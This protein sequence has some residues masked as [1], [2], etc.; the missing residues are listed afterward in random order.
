METEDALEKL[1]QY[2]ERS[3]KSM[4]D[5]EDKIREPNPI[6]EAFRSLAI[7]LTWFNAFVFAGLASFS[8]LGGV[9]SY[10]VMA[11]ATA[12]VSAI[13]TLQTLK[14]NVRL[15]VTNGRRTTLDDGFIIILAPLLLLSIYLVDY[16]NT[17]AFKIVHI[18]FSIMWVLQI[19]FLFFTKPDV[20]YMKDHLVAD[21]DEV[22]IFD[23][24]RKIVVIVGAL[25]GILLSIP[26][27]T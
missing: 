11:I 21:Y 14:A 22:E 13:V 23:T 18:A 5:K 17:A 10:K 12:I 25:S 24:P 15:T 19:Y 4:D 26:A 2:H 7:R 16:L 9:K 6:I 8:I 20:Q 3:K 27:F 1:A